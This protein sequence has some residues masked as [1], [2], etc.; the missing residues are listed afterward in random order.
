MLFNIQNICRGR[1]E[2]I[3]KRFEVKISENLSKKRL[4]LVF[5]G[6][7]LASLHRS[8]RAQKIQN[9]RFFLSMVEYS[10]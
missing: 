6:G 9:R 3:L 4:S 10:A 1:I 2:I 7:F 8:A 5:G